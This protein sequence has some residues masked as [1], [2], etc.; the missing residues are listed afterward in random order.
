MLFNGRASI[1][2]F[3]FSGTHVRIAEI[4]RLQSLFKMSVYNTGGSRLQISSHFLLVL[5][6]GRERCYVC[7]TD[8]VY[9]TWNAC[10]SAS[11]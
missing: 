9:T 3:T 4:E 8:A 5:S 1:F 2:I 7:Y 10:V 11:V 6:L